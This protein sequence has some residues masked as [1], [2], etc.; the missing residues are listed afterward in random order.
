MNPDP[1]C[2][3]TN[4]C[5]SVVRKPKAVP[6]YTLVYDDAAQEAKLMLWDKYVNAHKPPTTDWAMKYNPGKQAIDLVFWRN[7]VPGGGYKILSVSDFF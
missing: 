6:E 3:G 5:V 2:L 7:Y 4:E 1:N